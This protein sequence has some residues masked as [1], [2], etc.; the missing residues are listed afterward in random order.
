MS[1]RT[2]SFLDWQMSSYNSC[3]RLGTKATAPLTRSYVNIYHTD[4]SA[5]MSSMDATS[6][7]RE[8]SP[9]IYQL[10]HFPA[11]MS[12]VILTYIS[13]LWNNDGVR[14]RTHVWVIINRKK[15]RPVKSSILTFVYWH[16]QQ[17]WRMFTYSSSPSSAGAYWKGC[18]SGK[19]NNEGSELI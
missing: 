2:P 13:I 17:K 5:I 12:N 3:L 14:T 9:I 1:R 11:I 8:S 6:F 4:I 10:T 16:Y 7:S 15:L 18:N 19:K